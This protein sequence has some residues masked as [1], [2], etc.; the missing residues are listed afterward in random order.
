MSTMM[1]KK[2]S[3]I[4][5]SF[6][7]LTI[8]VMGNIAVVTAAD[9]VSSEDGAV[10]QQSD[11]L[12]ELFQHF[13]KN[14]DESHYQA[15]FNLS[16]ADNRPLTEILALNSQDTWNSVVGYIAKS[17]FILSAAY[18]Y[19]NLSNSDFLKRLNIQ[20][21]TWNTHIV[22]LG[23]QLSEF[24]KVLVSDKR[25]GQQFHNL[26]TSR[27]QLTTL[28][29]LKYLAQAVTDAKASDEAI[30]NAWSKAKPVIET[31]LEK[32]NLLSSSI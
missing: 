27:F 9:S 18:S 14:F 25:F 5:K 22:G 7:L 19:R 20:K 12:I 2:I 30:N 13:T 24:G 3:L 23:N 29:H 32:H 11:N 26:I 6:V 8:G 10:F 16:K 21:E 31:Y 1:H 4:G 15:T 28:M 17:D